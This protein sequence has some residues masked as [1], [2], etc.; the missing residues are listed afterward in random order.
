[1]ILLAAESS[2]ADLMVLV[3]AL[4]EVEEVIVVIVGSVL[5]ITVA[6]LARAEE[7]HSPAVL[8]KAG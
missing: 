2:K 7:C 1:M 4:G 8:H 6:P 3:D 5:Y